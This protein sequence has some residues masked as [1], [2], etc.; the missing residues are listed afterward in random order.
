[1]S[2][3]KV[4]VVDD[5]R[6]AREGLA[7]L[8]I[9]DGYEARPARDG[10]EALKAV[11]EWLPDVVVA[12]L[13]M[14]GMDGVELLRRAREID[15]DV[16]FV[17]MT[18]YGTVETAVQAM[19]EGADDYLAKPI[20]VDE[21]EVHMEKA[22]ERRRLLAET[23]VLRARLRDRSR[24]QHM[25][26]SSPPMQALFK[27]I[28]QVAPSRATV[29]ILGESGTGKE[30]VAHA[31]HQRSPR[32]EGP[33]VPVSCAGLA[34]TVLESE[35]FGHEKGAFTG[36]TGQR[37]GR[38]EVAD[39]GTLFLDEVG[40]LDPGTQVKL[41]RFLQEHSF[42]RVGGNQTIKVDVRLIAASNRDL[43]QAVQDR[44]FRED[45]FYR[46]NVVVV[47]V[48]PLRERKSDIPILVDHFIREYARENAKAVQEIE[49]DALAR[50][51]SYDWPGNVPEL[52]NV[53]ER[54]V[55]LSTTEVITR[56]DLPEVLRQDM[57][58]PKAPS[59][60]VPGTPL[61]EIEKE[62]ILRTL[63]HVGGN[64]TQ[65]AELLGISVRNLQYKLKEY[66][67]NP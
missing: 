4:L 46:L 50:L 44:H 34:E 30:L 54:A 62:A 43:E 25:V 58:D 38:F 9:E 41:L 16:R 19:K 15:R 35:L 1:M 53:I 55:V 28:E 37:K 18:A 11:E 48:P 61:R 49:A 39:R 36:A 10:F 51:M 26:G 65:A 7:Q 33:F 67:E 45:L 59:F 42:E 6:N 52:E 63:A 22:I 5:E 21:L 56:E 13:K 57:G 17:M 66:S 14:P 3:G 40:E 27:V 12:D 31:I 32:K 8:L 24:F 47:R 23:R 2:K 29:L 20:D 64:R 60:F